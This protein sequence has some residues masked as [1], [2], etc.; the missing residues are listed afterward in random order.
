MKIGKYSIPRFH[1]DS[2]LVATRKIYEQFNSDEISAEDIAPIL[3]QKA[4][5]G[6]FLQKLAD[7]RSYG[8]IEGKKDKIIV[9]ELGKKATYGDDSE[10]TSAFEELVRNIPLWSKF[11]SKYGTSIKEENFWVDLARITGADRLES[12]KKAPAIRKAY[13][14]DV[15]YTKSAGEPQTTL[16][17]GVVEGET[18]A[19]RT[20]KMQV[21]S[22]AVK[23]ASG[24][25]WYPE[26]GQSPIEIKDDLSFAIA[27]KVLEAIKL[28]LKKK[29]KETVSKDDE[30]NSVK[31]NEESE[32]RA[33]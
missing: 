13:L 10:Q 8:L 21:Q 25:I 18:A 11:L 30:S 17:S 28:D 14:D 19:D 9:S 4:S 23:K 7:L 31:L 24:Y 33:S 5:S 29:Q 3:G 15:K 12:K 22:T 27:E 6:G 16:E 2:M 32:K 20:W 26:Y 1:L